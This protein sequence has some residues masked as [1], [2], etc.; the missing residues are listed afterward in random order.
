M[1]AQVD[2]DAQ[3]QASLQVEEQMRVTRPAKQ[4]LT[5][6]TEKQLKAG[7]HAF[8][9]NVPLDNE[10]ASDDDEQQ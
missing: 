5:L 8:A 4:W 9:A 3:L 10:P 6:G 2:Q 7:Y 1:E